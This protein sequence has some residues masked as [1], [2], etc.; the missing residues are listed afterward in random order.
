MRKGF[1]VALMLLGLTAIVGAVSQSGRRFDVQMTG[2][3]E[4]P[5]PGDPDGT[6]TA[7]LRVNGGEGVLAYELSVSNLATATA[8]HI[9]RG[10]AGQAGPVVVPL[11][12]PSSGAIKDT[13]HVDKAL[14]Q[15]IIRN[16]SAFYVNVHNADFPA[17][18]I[19]GQLSR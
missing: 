10:V 11:R 8:A 1:T 6:G 9:H 18:A 3:A 5:G 4:V 15:E 14:L 16:P 2:A 7:T 12:A 13:V 19:R 17:G